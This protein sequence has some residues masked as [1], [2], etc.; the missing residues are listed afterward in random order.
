MSLN[1]PET[2]PCTTVHGK[3]CLP[4]NWSLMPKRL[5]VYNLKSGNKAENQKN[6]MFCSPWSLCLWPFCTPKSPCLAGVES[7]S[8]TV[9]PMQGAQVQSWSGS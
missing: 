8:K 5:G 2:I 7:L 4:G 3:N 9:L 1:H 6:R